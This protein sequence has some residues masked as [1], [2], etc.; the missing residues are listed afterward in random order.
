MP[1][2]E[3]VESV[4]E[5]SF[6]IFIPKDVLSGDFIWVR[7]IKTQTKDISF[8]ILG[9]CTG[10]GIP[11]AMISMIAITTLN[12]IILNKKRYKPEKIL[13]KLN[14]RFNELL[15]EGSNQEIMYEGVDIG[16]LRIDHK[17]NELCY[18]GAN[19]DLVFIRDGELELI[20]GSKTA[21]GRITEKDYLY[22]CHCKTL[23][24]GD[25]MLMSSDGYH[26]QFGG[27][28]NK[29]FKK[30]YFYQLLEKISDQP[31][32]DL[33]PILIRNFDDW[34][35]ENEQVDDVS[36]IGIKA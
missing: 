8:A 16:V 35:G 30:K 22:H 1:S 19:R 36:I 34:K 32:G 10:H 23:K 15:Q 11:G 3:M 24:E 29:K 27:M 4:F 6:N 26:D 18:S 25:L 5:K 12:D 7:R 2:Q 13:E 14:I 21:V 20:K 33:K 9:D 31:I 17:N 28:H